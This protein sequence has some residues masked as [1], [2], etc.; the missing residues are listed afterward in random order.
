MLIVYGAAAVPSATDATSLRHVVVEPGGKPLRLNSG[1]LKLDAAA[2]DADDEDLFSVIGE[3]LRSLCDP[4]SRGA[5]TFLSG[6]WQWVVRRIE[7]DRAEIEDRLR[8]YGRLFAPEDY[9]FSAW[10]PL[11]RAHIAVPRAGAE[12]GLVACDF[13]FWTGTQAIAIDLGTATRSAGRQRDLDLLRAAGARVVQVPAAAG[14]SPGE[15]GTLPVEAVDFWQQEALPAG[16]AVSP[17]SAQ[18]SELSW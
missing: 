8:P 9:R 6:Y 15:H 2:L 18:A 10:L 7:Q 16:C 4:W 1:V 14:E 11:P 3:H 5:H 17:S 12:D 13:A